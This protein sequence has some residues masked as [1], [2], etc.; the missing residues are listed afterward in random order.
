[1]F[2]RSHR[3]EALCMALLVLFS[4]VPWSVHAHYCG[5]I[6]VDTAFFTQASDCGMEDPSHGNVPLRCS[7]T[8]SHCCKDTVLTFDDP[9]VLISSSTLIPSSQHDWMLP[10]AHLSLVLYEVSDTQLQESCTHPP[11]L[12]SR[13]IYKLNEVYRI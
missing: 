5:D 8:K 4:A 6:L 9:E 3:V 11:P 2:T 12:L 1:M 13:P 10:H 7:V